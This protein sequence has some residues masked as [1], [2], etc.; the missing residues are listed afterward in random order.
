[1]D[2]LKD[3][4]KFLPVTRCLNWR[5]R[6]PGDLCLPLPAVDR[7]MPDAFEYLPWLVRAGAHLAVLVLAA[8]R[9]IGPIGGF[10]SVR[11]ALSLPDREPKS[12]ALA[13]AV[14]VVIF[15]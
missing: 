1:M 4:E 11:H 8:Q 10:N 15:R 12:L 6:H 9:L 14:A 3:W 13:S 5:N 2:R 7:A